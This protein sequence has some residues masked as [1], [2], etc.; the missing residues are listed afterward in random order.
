MPIYMNYD[1][2]ALQGDV[3]SSAEPEFRYVNVRR[4][5]ATDDSGDEDALPHPAADDAITHGSII[6]A[7]DNTPSI[8]Q[9]P[10]DDLADAASIGLDAG[11]Y[12]MGHL[13]GSSD[14]F[15]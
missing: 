13:K 2:L 10:F 14:G 7:P 15:E 1:L 11:S 5:S 9:G 4:T 8:L 6:V 3:S 12:S